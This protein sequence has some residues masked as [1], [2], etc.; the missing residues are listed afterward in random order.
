MFCVVIIDIYFKKYYTYVM[1]YCKD[2]KNKIVV[3]GLL[4]VS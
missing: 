4:A 1:K 2:I 3:A